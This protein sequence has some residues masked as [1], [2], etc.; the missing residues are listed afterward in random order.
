M[1]PIAPDHT[2]TLDLVLLKLAQDYG[3]I[4][5]IDSPVI[6]RY[7]LHDL[8]VRFKLVPECFQYNGLQIALPLDREPQ[9]DD[10]VIKGKH[11]F[12]RSFRPKLYQLV[13]SGIIVPLRIA[14]ETGFESLE[15]VP[16]RIIYLSPTPSKNVTTLE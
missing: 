11:I 9:K 2:S 15:Y 1:I 3:K 5:N 14:Q 8:F 7:D 16:H 6:F 12:G 13:R 4:I 10:K